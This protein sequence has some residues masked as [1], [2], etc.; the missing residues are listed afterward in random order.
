MTFY[1]LVLE[2]YGGLGLVVPYNLSYLAHRHTLHFLVTVLCTVN[3]E[4]VKI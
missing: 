4:G 1:L 2:Y 3:A